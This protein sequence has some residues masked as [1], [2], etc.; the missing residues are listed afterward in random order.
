[1]KRIIYF[2]LL[3]ALFS[4]ACNTQADKTEER[5]LS[6]AE[7]L[8]RDSISKAEQRVK[9]DSLRKTNP[10]L[11]VPPDSTYT[12]DYTDKYPDGITKFKGYFRFGKRHGQWMSFYPNGL[13]WSEMNYD[14]GIPHGPNMTY[15]MDGK[16]RYAGFYKNG[17]K[18]SLWIFYDSLG[19]PVKKAIYKKGHLIKEMD[20]KK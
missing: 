6:Q 15:F 11:I 14:K 2:G 17:E 7:R 12:G 4:A 18:D 5:A 8:R 10:L 3:I 1:M 13:A 20:A 19:V 16:P 9:A